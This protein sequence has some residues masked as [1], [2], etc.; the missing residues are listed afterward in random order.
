MEIEINGAQWSFHLE[1][2]NGKEVL[3]ATWRDKGDTDTIWTTDE[4]TLPVVPE[5][6]EDWLDTLNWAVGQAGAIDKRDP[7]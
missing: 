4:T 3:A 7:G 5:E 1:T 6:A 2:V